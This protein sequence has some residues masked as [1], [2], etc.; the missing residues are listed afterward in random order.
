MAIFLHTGH[1]SKKDLKYG[2][3]PGLGENCTFQVL[4]SI[5]VDIYCFSSNSPGQTAEMEAGIQ[6]FFQ[7]L[8]ER[9]VLPFLVILQE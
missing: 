5:F 4:S 6:F 2:F 7:A 9:N 1:C 8:Q 3:C